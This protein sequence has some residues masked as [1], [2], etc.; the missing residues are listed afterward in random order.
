MVIDS[1]VLLLET[2]MQD[3]IKALQ[4]FAKYTD[5]KWPTHCEH[6]EMFVM[7]DPSDVSPEDLEVLEALSFTPSSTGETF[8]SYRFGSA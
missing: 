3:L 4:I 5:T 6:D 8:S 7:V 1:E 2:T